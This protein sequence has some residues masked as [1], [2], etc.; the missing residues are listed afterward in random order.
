MAGDEQ[1]HSA[2]GA[3]LAGARA[4]TRRGW[5]VIPVP[6]RSKK[7]GLRGWQKLRLDEDA[8]SEHFGD[9]PKNI[10]VLLGEPSDWVVDVDLD[11]PRALDLA[12]DFLPETPA[13]FGRAGKP[14]SH[15][16]Y[17]VTAPVAT[18]KHKSKSA[19]MIVELRSTGAQTIVPPS[20]H[21]SGESIVWSTEGADPAEVDPDQ[22]RDAVRRMADTVRVELGEKTAPKLKLHRSV[23]T[24]GKDNAADPR[25]E[26]LNAMLRMQTGDE[27]DGSGRLFAAACRCVEHDL[28]EEDAISLIRMYSS[29][30]P[31]PTQWTDDHIR[32]RL[33]DAEGKCQR[34]KA[35]NT[36]F[37]GNQASQL[38]ALA[39]EHGAAL[40]HDDDR[41]FAA[42]PANGHVETWPLRSASFRSW[43]L[44]LFYRATHGAPGSQSLQDA[45]GVLDAKARFDGPERRVAVRLAEL[46]GAIWLDLADAGWNVVRID[47]S[48][49]RLIASDATP[50]R[51]VRNRAMQPLPNPVVGGSIG[52]LRRFFNLRDESDWVLLLGWLVG[53][54]RPWGSHAI[55]N[56]SGEQGTAKTTLC[57][58]LRALV[59]PNK[60]PVRCEPNSRRD[61]MIAATSSWLVVLDNLSRVPTWLSDAL[62]R[63]A[64]GG[65]LSTREL[66]TDTDEIV[67]DAKRPLILNGIASVATRADLLDRCVSLTLDTIPE[68][69]R[70][71]D[72]DL[73]A[74]YETARPRILGALLDA[75]SVAMR[76]VRSIRLPAIPRMADFA[77]WATAAEPGLGLADG[78]FLR[79]YAGDRD[80]AHEA[81]IE[82]SPVGRAIVDLVTS[83]GAW[84]GTQTELLKE[85]NTETYSDD[86]ARRSPDWPRTPR[87]LA[88]ELRRLAPSL[89]AAGI[90]VVIPQR[91]TGRRKRKEI[92]LENESAQQS[93]WSARSADRPDDAVNIDSPRTVVP[94]EAPTDAP[95]RAAATS[96][97]G[98]ETADADRADHADHCADHDSCGVRADDP[99]S[100]K[101]ARTEIFEL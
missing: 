88:E 10:G 90:S 99:G 49:W 43:L 7:P 75:V 81:A 11:H 79:A 18:Q 15:W 44:R 51:F 26:C 12:K 5:R 86:H 89:R 34:G 21:E 83:V 96:V 22:L 32:Q 38:I 1:A 74:E 25:G 63:L 4:Y 19:G 87:K 80:A 48:G 60:S 98:P 42:V 55:L 24:G 47:A 20:A 85:I 41:A 82:N 27:R 54:F 100:E 50:V 101:G 56:V 45:L 69:R 93:A 76:R 9:E 3:A 28:S 66:Y 95:Q 91:R 29:L 72:A 73:W 39:E 13:V 67:L 62:C 40:F 23:D 17:R 6:F 31:F 71:T 33:R 78:A 97:S 35:L 37:P 14:R 57:R 61:L 58:I 84:T 52:E 36:S 92:V 46:D 70:R 30:A 68:D 59:D 65:G 94:R 77:V 64:T 2:K 8:L 16:L 53:A